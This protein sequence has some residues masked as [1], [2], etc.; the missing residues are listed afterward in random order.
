MTDTDP[1]S[2][3]EFVLGQMDMKL[4]NICTQI[5]EIKGAMECKTKDCE[6]C[7]EGI[8]GDIDTLHTRINGLKETHTGE[9]AVKKWRGKTLGET[10]TIIG[11]GLGIITFIVWVYRFFTSGDLP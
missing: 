10:G 5:T 9:A 2:S 7:K 4:T 6:E 3:L 8:E 1:R 11:A